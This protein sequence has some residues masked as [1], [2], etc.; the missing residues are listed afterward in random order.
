LLGGD[1]EV[2]VL[3]W[4]WGAARHVPELVRAYPAAR[5]VL[6]IDT[7]PN[8]SMVGTEIRELAVAQRARRRLAGLITTSGQMTDAVHRRVPWSRGIPTLEW[9]SPLPLEAHAP[10]TCE[11]DEARPRDG[12]EPRLIFVGRSD[13]LFAKTRRMGKDDVGETLAAYSRAGARVYVRRPR[14]ATAAASLQGHGF[15]FYPEFSNADV[16]SG[17]F[18]AYVGGFH[19]QLVLYRVANGTVRRRVANGLS[20]RWATGIASP[21]PVVVQ[22]AARAAASF[23]EAVPIGVVGDSVETNIDELL[24][25]QLQMRQCWWNTHEKW[26]AKGMGATLREFFGGLV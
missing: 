9:S 17:T 18:A 11:K 5:F 1:P 4:G 26:S 21:A 3:W 12:E 14:S 6:C 20:T 15:E 8:A 13:Y 19:G 22:T 16:L 23:L 10:K 25:R 2:V 24:T 7:F